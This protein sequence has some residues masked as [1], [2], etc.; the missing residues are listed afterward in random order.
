M[1]VGE[2]ASG[3]RHL[4][5]GREVRAGLLAFAAGDP[6]LGEDQRATLREAASEVEGALERAS[7]AVKAYRDFLE[8]ERVHGRAAAR[9]AQW[10]SEEAPGASAAISEAWRAEERAEE[11]RRERKAR[12]ADAKAGLRGALERVI[13]RLGGDP[14]LLARLRAILPPLADGELAVRDVGDEDDDAAAP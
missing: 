11:E 13:A 2:G 7:A 8:R 3:L 10:L 9:L 6:G 12:L 5:F 1:L 4:R 14:G